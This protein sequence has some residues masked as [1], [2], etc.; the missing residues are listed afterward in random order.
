MQ[1]FTQIK[2]WERSHAFVLAIYHESK[3][4]PRH[5]LFGITSQLRRAAVSV[6]CNIAEGSKR[7]H[8][9][10]YARFLNIAEASI[11]EVEALLMISRDVGYL[12]PTRAAQLLDEADAIARMASVLR[13]AVESTER[14]MLRSI[15]TSPP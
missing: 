8:Q 1:R 5:E 9:G 4:F 10:D 6:S 15:A 12:V 14:R 13:Q 11:A 7:R 2:T 3:T